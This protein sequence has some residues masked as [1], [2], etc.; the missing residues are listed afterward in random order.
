M[1]LSITSE[2][3]VRKYKKPNEEIIQC[4]CGCVKARH[5]IKSNRG[6]AS[7]DR[8]LV[9]CLKHYPV[10]KYNDEPYPINV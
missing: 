4:G 6:S 10:D 2:L 8:T 9:F 5:D 3:I 7:R 1:K